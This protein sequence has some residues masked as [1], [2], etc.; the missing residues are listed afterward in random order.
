MVK[1]Y[2]YNLSVFIESESTFS[3]VDG[4][5][6]VGTAEW[7]NVGKCRDEINSGRKEVSQDGS[8]Y[9]YNAVIYCHKSTPSILKGAKVKV[10]DE[11]GNI[12]IESNLVRYQ[13]EQLHTRLWV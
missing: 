4:S 3:E 13:N 10:T 7:V 6:S 12:R 8:E 2:P 1:I 9:V 5:W 11:S